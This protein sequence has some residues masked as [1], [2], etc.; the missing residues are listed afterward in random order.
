MYAKTR[1]TC[2]AENMV[3]VMFFKAILHTIIKDSISLHEQYGGF[4]CFYYAFYLHLSPCHH[5]LQ[6]FG[7]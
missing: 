6:L 7:R 1:D 4:S 3:S 2:K 5:L